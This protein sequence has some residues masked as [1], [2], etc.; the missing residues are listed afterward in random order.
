M[1]TRPACHDSGGQF[2]GVAAYVKDYVPVR[3]N[4]VT[5][6]TIAKPRGRLCLAPRRAL[7][8][9]VKCR[10]TPPLRLQEQQVVIDKQFV[11]SKL[12]LRQSRLRPR[13]VG[14]TTYPRAE[15][16]GQIR[17]TVAASP[18]YRPA[19]LEQF[20]QHCRAKLSPPKFRRETKNHE[21]FPPGRRAPLD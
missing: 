4:R 15:G 18:R 14:R 21:K 12:V 17:P 11:Q 5:E 8:W 3:G 1:S 20:P 2:Q 6:Q 19:R 16:K 13:L 7:W 9:R 10:Q